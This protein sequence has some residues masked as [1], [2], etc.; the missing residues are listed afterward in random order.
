MHVTHIRGLV[1]VKF[2]FHTFELDV[3][4]MTA[5]GDRLTHPRYSQ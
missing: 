4:F 5:S 3:G 1:E 2:C